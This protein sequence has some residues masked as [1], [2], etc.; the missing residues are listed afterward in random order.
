[1]PRRPIIIRKKQWEAGGLYEGGRGFGNQAK[2]ARA[3]T[4]ATLFSLSLSHAPRWKWEGV[5]GEEKKAKGR[6]RCRSFKR[7]R[8]IDLGKINFKTGRQ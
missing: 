1:M 4:S 8:W 6:S 3:D 7:R 2:D 5:G